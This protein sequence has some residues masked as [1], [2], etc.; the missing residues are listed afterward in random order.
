MPNSRVTFLQ[1]DLSSLEAVKKAA[2]EFRQKSDRLDILINNAGIMAVPSSSTVDGLEIQFGTNHVSHALLTRL[3]MPTLLRTAEQPN[4]DVRVINL[5]SEGHQ[6]APWAGIVY[7]QK[8]LLQWGAWRRYGQSKL[9]NILHAREL[10][11]KYPTITAT[12]IH[13][14]IIMTGLYTSVN[15][16]STFMRIST[17]L[18]GRIFMD[19]P[20]GA[21]NT[22]WAATGPRETVRSSWYFKPVGSKS[23]GSMWHAQKP[24]LAEQLWDWTEKELEAKGY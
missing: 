20:N 3:L 15:S 14:G 17:W 4:S 22:L 19:V 8:E 12:A 11:R 9:A 23:A 5:S 1:L 21:K 18:M 13:P 2:D 24:Q 10:Q 6:M 16:T 7:D